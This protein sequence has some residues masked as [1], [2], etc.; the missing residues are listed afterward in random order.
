M[1]QNQEDAQFARRVKVHVTIGGHDATD[2][3]KP[4]L[5]DFAFTDNATGKADEIQITLHDRDGRWSN[6]WKPKKGMEATAAIVCSDWFTR[7]DSLSLPCGRFRIDEIEFSGPPD[8]IKIKAVTSA[9]T[10]GLR[11]TRKTRAWEN[12]SLRTVAGQV[13]A[14]H[15]LALHYAGDGHAFERQD[16]RDESDLG[17]V[18]RMAVERGMFCKA[19]DNRLI[20]IDA[21]TA[22][23]SEAALTIRRT[24]G[25]F[26][27]KKYDFKQAGSKTAYTGA[28]VEYTDPAEGKVHTATVT[29]ADAGEKS[30]EKMLELNRRVESAEAAVRLAKGEMNGENAKE[31]TA[32]MEIMGHPGLVAGMTVELSGFGDFSGR[33]IVKK[34]EHKVGSGGYATSLELTKCR[35][36]PD[37]VV[38]A[39]S[40][41]LAT[42]PAPAPVKVNSGVNP[43]EKW[44]NEFRLFKDFW[45]LSGVDDLTRLLFCLP[46]IADN[47]AS[48]AGNA[49]DAQGWLHLRSMF[50]HWFGGKASTASGAT[51]PFWVDWDWIMRYARAFAAYV[52]FTMNVEQLPAEEQQANNIYNAAARDSLGRILCRDGYMR[53]G[54]TDFD[55]TVLP[56][57]EWQA[58]YHTHIAVPR[59]GETD[60]LMAA[61]GAFTL[62]ALAAGWTEPGG[63]GGHI[64]HVTKMAVF[65]HDVFNFEGDEPLGYWSCEQLRADKFSFPGGER[66][67]NATFR[68][69]RNSR[70]HG[71]DFLVLSLPHI[72]ESF[73]GVR[74]VYT[75]AN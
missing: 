66:M 31:N 8:K 27:A 34:A 16:Q 73:S 62:R 51:E 42:R 15:G 57:T 47:M 39:G 7:G 54:R 64:V 6:E 29:A 12:A 18:D 24:G 49:A 61:M 67:H 43:L 20:L 13:A 2:H 70:K 63:G 38:K 65:V 74:Y 55:F 11:D 71:G 60:G 36:K 53:D 56:W 37:V 59:S 69:F 23:Q 25:R 52:A 14:E 44:E 72:V 26:P 35:L 1:S 5:L 9:L 32:T 30:N 50:H 28:H 17:F 22:E 75:C 58:A 46:D 10:T 48:Q 19:H 41:E 40:A 3:M 21:E 4:Y 45:L 33:Y 68:E